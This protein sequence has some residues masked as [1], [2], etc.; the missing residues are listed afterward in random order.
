MASVV[1]AAGACFIL[2]SVK[3]PILFDVGANKLALVTFTV[4]THSELVSG[5]IIYW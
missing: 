4:R 2:T 5:K 1:S 3:S